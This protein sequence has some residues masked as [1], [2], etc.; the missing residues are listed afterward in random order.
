MTPRRVYQHLADLAAGQEGLLSGAQLRTAAA[1]GDPLT[2]WE[3]R[4]LVSSGWLRPVAPRVFAINGVPETHR[5]RLR[6]GLLGLGEQ[7]WVSY[8]AAATLHGLDRSRPDSVEFTVPRVGRNR[9]CPFTVHTTEMLEPIDF[10][11]VDGFRSMSATRTIIDLAHSRAH[12]RRVEAAIDSAVRL[13]LSSPEVIAVR[14]ETVRG[15]GRWG[16]RLLDELIVDSGGHSMLERRF[17]Q[18]VREAGLPRPR[19]QVIHRKNGRHIARV[20]FLFERAGVVVEV[21]G[22]HGHS[23]PSE[24]ARDAQRRNELQDI[25]RRVFEYTWEDVTERPA[26]VRR[27]LIER[28]HPRARTAEIPRLRHAN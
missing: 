3:R 4:M 1:S 9:S 18:L 27:T 10:V 28:L 14:L 8:E 15:S 23:S 2:E 17:L 13:G 11:E 25:G 24:R 12:I 7:S 22:R 16:C 20:D 6:L 21:S 19:T 5:F 26:M